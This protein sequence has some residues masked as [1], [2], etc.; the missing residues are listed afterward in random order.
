MLR[1]NRKLII[2]SENYNLIDEL[3]KLAKKEELNIIGY[4]GD[5]YYTS[6]LLYRLRFDRGLEIF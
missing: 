5:W 2:S 6:D 1:C 4:N 3:I